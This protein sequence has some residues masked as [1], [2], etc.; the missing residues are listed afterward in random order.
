MSRN[1]VI[2]YSDANGNCRVVIPTMDCALSD[3][4]VIAKDIPTSDY[5]VIDP[6]DLPSKDFRS[7]WTYNHGSKTVTANLTKAK[8]LT[9]ETLETKYLAIKK[10]NADI[11]AIADMKGES[12]S[13]KSNPSV[14][15][16]TINNATTISELEALI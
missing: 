7:A 4:A 15:Y 12:A 13:L 10:E 3:E 16:T 5:S 11:Q 14:P 6:A 8:T 1:K 2:A 9:T